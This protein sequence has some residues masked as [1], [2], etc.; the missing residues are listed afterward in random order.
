MDEHI[1]ALGR[2]P[3]GQEKQSLAE[4]PGPQPTDPALL[5]ARKGACREGGHNACWMWQN[6]PGSSQSSVCAY[7]QACVCMYACF[8]VHL[9]TCVY[10]CEWG[11]G[12]DSSMNPS[13]AWSPLSPF[14]S[15]NLAPH[16][17]SENSLPSP[18]SGAPPLH[19]TP[20]QHIYKVP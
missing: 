19:R 12:P 14:P 8:C 9:C 16:P 20:S 13:P 3:L 2:K 7:V 1:K 4:H 17:P 6:G 11:G 10:A 5:T 15:Q 18:P